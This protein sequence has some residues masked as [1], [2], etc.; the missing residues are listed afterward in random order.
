MTLIK[1]I[2]SYNKQ[3]V[4][5]K[6]FEPYQTSKYPDKR[7][8]ILACMDTR[9]IEL[10]PQAL[11]LKNGDAK[12]IKTAGAVVSHPFG[13]IMRSIL[14]AIY[15]LNAEEV[16][17]I[18]HYDCGMGCVNPNKMK[19]KFIERGIPEST[20]QTIEYSGINL[21]A[22]LKGFDSVKE[23]VKNSVNIIKNHPLIPENILVHGLI[24]DPATGKLDV[25]AEDQHTSKGQ[26]VKAI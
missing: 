10:L 26:G 15:E 5:E 20:L 19:Y 22:W 9:L 8:C 24:I 11:N 6:R 14:L 4:E 17:V 16:F 23:S 12:I 2:L 25:V 18:G 3:F 21:E 1:D 7:F 13:S